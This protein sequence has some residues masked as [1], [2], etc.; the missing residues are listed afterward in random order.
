MPN[1]LN[2]LPDYLQQF[3]SQLLPWVLQQVLKK[4]EDLSPLIQSIRQAWTFKIPVTFLAQAA[5]MINR[6]AFN[7]EQQQQMTNN[8]G[9]A[10]G[11]APS[12]PPQEDEAVTQT[13]MDADT[14]LRYVEIE[15]EINRLEAMN[16][17]EHLQIKWDELKALDEEIQR[18]TAVFESRKEQTRKEKQDVDEMQQISVNSFIADKAAFDERMSREQE[19]FVT[20]LNKQ[21]VAQRELESAVRIRESARQAVKELH[22]HANRLQGLYRDQDVML[23]AIFDGKYGSELEFRLEREHDATS[24]RQQRI[25]AAKA[26][27]Q[28]GRLLI[29]HA[30]AQLGHGVKQWET[31]GSMPPQDM[32]RR[33]AVATETRNYLVAACANLRNSQNYLKGIDFPYCK[34][35]EVVTLERATSNIFT[36]VATLDRHMHAMSVY[37]AM[38]QRAGALLQWF[39]TVINKTIDRDLLSAT[40]EL[41]EKKRL[42]RTERVRLIKQKLEELLGPQAAAEAGLDEDA[43][44]T[45]ARRLQEQLETLNQD[46]MQKLMTNVQVVQPEGVQPS[47]MGIEATPE[48]AGSKKRSKKSRKGKEKSNDEAAAEGEGSAET[49]QAS[50][51]ESMPKIDAVS[52]KDLA[53]PPSQDQLFGDIDSI[54]KQYE[55]DMEEYQRAQEL[56][57]TRVERGLQEKLAARKTRKARRMAQEQ[58]T[59]KLLNDSVTA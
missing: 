34:L 31:C 21:E 23:A 3:A 19:E 58:E 29:H 6:S 15:K 51:M 30:C 18:L 40:E 37:R 10:N 35:D 11:S 41:F 14:L 49:P 16:S 9:H 43:N 17:V 13:T 24:D 25:A 22:E 57:R 33:Y 45:D 38:F 20:A 47:P 39:D 27:W 1:N 55:I 7:F 2:I 56:N 48:I 46:E 52:L 42:L 50:A 4:A 59:E 28:A 44:L 12:A 53:P 5:K 36:D 32:Q 54:K 26:R 8:N